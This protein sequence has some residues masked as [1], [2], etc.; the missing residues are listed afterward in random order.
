MSVFAPSTWAM[1]K[2]LKSLHNKKNIQCKAITNSKKKRLCLDSAN[3][4]L[5]R[6]Q[7]ELIKRVITQDCPQNKNA[8]F[9]KKKGQIALNNV[10][11]KLAR[12]L[13]RSKKR[14]LKGF[15]RY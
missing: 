8:D 10:Q 4:D 7:L 14:R 1:W 11:K 12:M 2:Q 13:N 9:C 6:K 15:Y 3:I 5:Y